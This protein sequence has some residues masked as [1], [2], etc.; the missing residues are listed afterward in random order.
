M[1]G[2]KCSTSSRSLYIH[3]YILFSIELI[4]RLSCHLPSLILHVHIN[5]IGNGACNRR[6]TREYGQ[7]NWDTAAHSDEERERENKK[8]PHTPRQEVKVCITSC[9]AYVCSEHVN[10]LY[11]T[12]KSDEEEE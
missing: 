9:V 1:A 2:D 5:K 6:T 4:R 12:I 11:T 7:C 8:K 3:I 10:L